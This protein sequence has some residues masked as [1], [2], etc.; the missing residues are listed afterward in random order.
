MQGKAHHLLR[1]WGPEDNAG[2]LSPS[3]S[4]LES[5]TCGNV[6]HEDRLLCLTYRHWARGSR[7]ATGCPP[8]NT[9]RAT[10]AF[11]ATRCRLSMVSASNKPLG[12]SP[13]WT[14]GRR[15]PASGSCPMPLELMHPPPVFHAEADHG[16][17]SSPH[18]ANHC[19][20]GHHLRTRRDRARDRRNSVIKVPMPASGLARLA[21][22]PLGRA[23][24]KPSKRSPP[25]PASSS[26]LSG[27]PP[28]STGRAPCSPGPAEAPGRASRRVISGP[29]GRC[30]V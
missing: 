14:G 24:Q 11:P 20:F 23:A 21:I 28:R 10:A 2:K 1:L 19:P 8:L 13:A 3:R 9:N 29:C 16:P 30:M 26:T 4:S 15:L 17:F 6:S 12:V 27:C 5:A 18:K 7:C 25:P 22:D